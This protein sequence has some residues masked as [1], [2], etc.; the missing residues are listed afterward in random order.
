MW[1]QAGPNSVFSAT[2]SA[3][4]SFLNNDD[5]AK[6]TIPILL[7]PSKDEA[8]LVSCREEAGRSTALRRDPDHA[9]D[10]MH[11]NITRR[12]A[13]SS[14]VVSGVCGCNVAC[15]ACASD[16]VHQ[17]RVRQGRAGLA[18]PLRRHAPRMG[19]RKVRQ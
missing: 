3:H 14:T 16:G 11:R 12:H 19:R 17:H 7:L 2:A 13:A 10:D 5:A 18:A 4:P 8:D 6:V 15:P 9:L 1:V